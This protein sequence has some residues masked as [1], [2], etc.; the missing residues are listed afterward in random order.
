MFM[1]HQKKMMFSKY[2]FVKYALRIV[3]ILT[4]YPLHLTT[5]QLQ[6]RVFTCTELHPRIYSYTSSNIFNICSQGLYGL[7]A[8]RQFHLVSATNHLKPIKVAR[9]QQVTILS[10]YLKAISVKTVN[11]T[12]ALLALFV[13][14]SQLFMSY[15]LKRN[16]AQIHSK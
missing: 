11:D 6:T 10:N 15:L 12:L 1:Y 13:L 3:L 16:I 5:C 9:N 7:T 8:I 2:C 4:K 14:P